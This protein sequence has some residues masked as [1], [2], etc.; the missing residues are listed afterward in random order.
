MEEEIM[1]EEVMDKEEIED[2]IEIGG[3]SMGKATYSTR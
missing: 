1:E 2:K 3:R